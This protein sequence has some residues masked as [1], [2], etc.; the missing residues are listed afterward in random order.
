MHFYNNRLL[1]INLCWLA[2]GSQ[3]V[4][5]LRLL[6]SKFELDQSQCKSMQVVTS[7]CKWVAKWNVSWTQVQNLH[8]YISSYTWSP[9]NTWI[10]IMYYGMLGQVYFHSDVI[11]KQCRSSFVAYYFSFL[12]LHVISQDFDSPCL[13]TKKHWHSF[14]SE[15]FLD[16]T[17]WPNIQYSISHLCFESDNFEYPT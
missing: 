13:K 11:M 4:K 17:G 3:T 16:S 14:T 10:Y 6:V 8:Q 1:A 7:Q 5:N 15:F 9:L 12:H 2:L